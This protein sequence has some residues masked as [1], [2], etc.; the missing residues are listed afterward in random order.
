MF[1]AE[2]AAA[3]VWAE[4]FLAWRALA[5]TKV[6]ASLMALAFQVPNHG[7]VEASWAPVPL[8]AYK[9][10]MLAA[11]NLA[12]ATS[13]TRTLH[14]YSAS[15]A[16]AQALSVFFCD[17][18]RFKSSI[19]SSCNS[20]VG[21]IIKF[22]TSSFNRGSRLS[23]S[24]FISSPGRFVMIKSPSIVSFNPGVVLCDVSSVL[25]NSIFGISTGLCSI[26]FFSFS[27]CGSCWFAFFCI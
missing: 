8:V 17:I 4:T 9:L 13:L 15:W 18:F 11:V 22:S 24:D 2:I 14:S 12:I 26:G 27:S 19:L 3:A 6:L 20:L 23:S 7:W 25:I 10:S 16:V 21:I 1:L 5:A